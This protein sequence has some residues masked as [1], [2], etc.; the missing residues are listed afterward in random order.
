MKKLISILLVVVMLVA[1]VPAMAFTTSADTAAV[2]PSGKWTD[3]GNY[4]LSWATPLITDTATD[5]Q[6]VTIDGK[7]YTIKYH[8]GTYEIDTAKKL[9]GVAVLA[10]AASIESFSGTVFKITEDIDLGAHY[11]DPIANQNT[12]NGSGKKFR[13][14]ITAESETAIKNMTI[15]DTAN[16]INNCYGLVGCQGGGQANNAAGVSATGTI[17]NI[18]LE[19]AS[20]NVK[21][22]NVGSFVGK[23]LHGYVDYKNLKSDAKIICSTGIDSSTG[24]YVANSEAWN[25]VGGICGRVDGWGGKDQKFVNCVFTGSLDTPTASAVGGIVGV[26]RITTINETMTFEKCV[27]AIDYIRYGA[28]RPGGYNAWYGGCAGI[29]GCHIAGTSDTD[30]NG[31]QKVDEGA[32][33][34]NVM[35]LKECYV[36]IGE[37][38]VYAEQDTPTNAHEGVAGMVGNQGNAN[39]S[40]TN[41]QM[42][43]AVGNSNTATHL[44]TYVGRNFG[45]TT[46]TNC[47][48]TGI[49][50]RIKGASWNNHNTFAWSARNPGIT[51][52]GNNFASF[53]QRYGWDVTATTPTV[54]ESVDTWKNKLDSTVW[55]ERDGSIY[56]ILTV[57][58]DYAQYSVSGAGVDYSFFN[59]SGCKA[60]TVE[61][62][63]ALDYILQAMVSYADETINQK[64][65]LSPALATADMT[66][67]SANSVA[68]I[69]AKLGVAAD[70]DDGTVFDMSK[71]KIFAQTSLDANA[72]GT[73][74]IR[75]VI[76]LNDK[77]ACD[78]I[79]FDVAGSRGD[80]FGATLESEL[81]TK[82]YKTVIEVT[83]EGNVMHTADG[84]AYYV[85]CVLK[86]V[87]LSE[88]TT[89]TVRANAVTLAEDGVTV[90]STVTQSTAVN[91]TV[92]AH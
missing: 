50:A 8:V 88:D 30:A 60:T 51:D 92:T 18:T 38:T 48:N 75:F 21:N 41:C 67:F 64:V 81:I 52:G 59:I 7:I 31:D 85:V 77:T 72:N 4:D 54:I 86:N 36:A 62:L 1:M 5:G 44:A 61:E 25:A 26:N 73:Y 78:G 66:G 90:E 13:G 14:T 40:F 53:T 42:D 56:P 29:V 24:K 63:N 45:A 65:S 17:T 10:N 32:V 58:K 80:K 84:D 70:V 49:V 16:N 33:E 69:N 23:I 2:T 34:T 9:A 6:S 57:A 91:F 76:L 35:Y 39:L 87:D 46:F 20:I 15:V 3:S 12:T 43:I 71:D 47:V 55:S 68:L 28:E 27:V 37:Y 74:N 89:F 83:S 22:G 19:N 11:W 82:C 79:K